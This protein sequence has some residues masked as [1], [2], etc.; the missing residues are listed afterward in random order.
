MSD[1]T[2]VPSAISGNTKHAVIARALMQDIVSRKYPVG[3][4]LPSEPELAQSLGVSRQT[5][6]VALR[7][8]R[9]LGLIAGAQGVGSFVKAGA[10]S[11]RLG[12]TFD[13]IRDLL[14]YANDTRVRMISR[15]EITLT[16]EQATWLDR[17]P[18]EVWWE[19][20]TVR[21]SPDSVSP[22]ASSIILLPYVFGQVLT[23][24]E[25]SSEA[26]FTLIERRMGESITEIV[27]NICIAY[28]D[29]LHAHAL[30]V[31]TGEAV[32]C[33]ERRYF[34][35]NGD[36]LEVSRTLHPADRFQYGMRVR[37]Q[38]GQDSRF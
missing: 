21:V 20:H 23:E 11:T 14:Q 9:D 10:P 32:M 15:R 36:L 34:G 35:R 18:G 17:K 22:V 25:K 29:E 13:S 33:M 16:V 30:G 5:I 6:R 37:V 24:V 4:Q 27:Q 31:A 26:I 12:Y 7:H 8:L 38:S 28:A 19:V 1:L 3:T 2:Q